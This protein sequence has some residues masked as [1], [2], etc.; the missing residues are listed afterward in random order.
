[1]VRG[2][3]FIGL[4]DI[5][6]PMAKRIA[7]Q[8]Y[9]VTVCGHARREPIEEMKTLR[10]TEVSTPREVAQASEIT[11][12]M[13]RDDP[14]TKA[15]GIGVLDA[16]VTGARMRA[17]TGELGIMVGGDRELVEKYRPVLEAMGKIIYCGDLGSGEIVKLANNMAL[18][19]NLIGAYE[20]VSWGMKNGVSE[21]LLVG[22]MK[23]GTGNSWAIQNWEFL[24]SA[25]VE[26]PP[27]TFYLAAKDLDY[28]LRIAHDVGQPCPITALCRERLVAGVLKLPKV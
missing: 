13:A 8:G 5:G 16:P 25:Q 20:A 10:A 4:G 26:P 2:V 21:E 15:K 1:M 7:S 12:T 9:K 19:I 17:A 24:K 22:L 11:I 23:T 6:L 14:Q 28:A 3:G 18:M 27:V